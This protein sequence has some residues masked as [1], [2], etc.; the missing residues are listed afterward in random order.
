MW[1]MRLAEGQVD[2]VRVQR[3]LDQEGIGELDQG[4]QQDLQWCRIN[5]RCCTIGLGQL[6]DVEIYYDLQ[7]FSHFWRIQIK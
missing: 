1:A 7:K 6:V 2:S 5:L 4:V 3:T